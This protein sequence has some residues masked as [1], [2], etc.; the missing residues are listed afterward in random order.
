MS[1][2]WER[3]RGRVG[4]ALCVGILVLGVAPGAAAD[5]I[6]DAMAAMQRGDA[7]AAHALLVSLVEADEVKPT[8]LLH[9]AWMAVQ[10]GDADLCRRIR[11]VG[12]ALEMDD[13]RDDALHLALGY[14]YL[15]LAEH[16]VRTG[17]G[18][19]STSLLFADAASR[20][21]TLVG[22]GNAS[23]VYLAARTRYSQGD[24]PGALDVLLA[25]EQAQD[26]TL[27]A[28]VATQL[29]AYLYERAASMPAASDGRPTAD[30]RAD[31][32][33]AVRLLRAHLGDATLLAPATRRRLRLT[34]AWAAHRLGQYADA[35]GAYLDAH[36]LGGEPAALARRGL[37]SLFAHDADALSKAL[38]EAAAQHPA[39]PAPLDDLLRIHAEGKRYREAL[40]VLQ[41][42]LEAHPQDA[43]GYR[44]GGD[45]FTVMRQW[46][47]AVE[48][49][50]AA[51]ERDPADLQAAF[52]I[53]RVAQ[54][55]VQ[56]DF[57]RALAIYERLL[58]LR[59]AD[60]YCRNNL[61]FILRERV[62]PWTDVQPG[63]IQTLK[64]D[65]PESIRRLL[66]RC[67]DAY[68]SA[69]ALIP[70]DEDESR[71][72]AESWNLAGIVND[73]GL[74]IHYFADI[75]DAPL[76][77]QQYLRTLRMTED[78]FK[79]TYSPNLQRL[80]A[81][82]LKERELSWYRLARRCKDAI[83]MERRVDGRM[84]LVADER[85]RRAA[86]ADEARLRAR[87]VQELARDAADDGSPWPPEGTEGKGR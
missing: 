69:V 9:A 38:A 62:S 46:G 63:G 17:T 61:G 12:E 24:L 56:D 72:M 26:E 57:D 40:L 15:G 86:A 35:R 14:A 1:V 10:L 36:A 28:A 49:Y 22:K 82:V 59:P 71:E 45:L 60:P 52:G 76:A 25:H 42:R 80:Y 30:A 21:A 23:A 65:A 48:H 8:Q 53:E 44:L 47:E 37:A 81:F 13:T 43:R 84:E 11:A 7:D 4:V 83:L 79:D 20:A 54:A 34:I 87:I 64:A 31:L 33:H 77:E 5:E 32:D 75:Q 39:D 19:S 58:E 29:G 6:T 85:K 50:A 2:A 67:R 66:F 16:Q 78:G 73:Y 18:G 41:Q 55:L 70:E 68:A 27:G 51:L 74:M 3:A